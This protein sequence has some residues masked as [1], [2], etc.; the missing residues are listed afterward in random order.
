MA[1][2]SR[3]ATTGDAAGTRPRSPV[4]QPPVSL[5]RGTPLGVGVD[6]ESVSRFRREFERKSDFLSKAFT[7]LEFSYCMAKADPPMH[8]AGTFA[9]KEAA[10]KSTSW[11]RTG[12]AGASDFE[13][14]RDFDGTPSVTCRREKPL[15]PAAKF[16]VS[17]SHTRQTAVAVVLSISQ[18]ARVEWEGIPGTSPK[19]T[20]RPKSTARIQHPPENERRP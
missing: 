7:A 15:S 16:E 11:V 20:A 9:A 12:G 5:N 17:I 3:A 1:R 4:Y 14:S 8:F 18:P 6:I 13:V 19:G 2:R 10:F